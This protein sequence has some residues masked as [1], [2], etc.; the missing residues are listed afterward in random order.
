M[1]NLSSMRAISPIG[2]II[3]AQMICS[4]TPAHATS[5]A[6]NSAGATYYLG[7]AN[8]Q[9]VSRTAGLFAVGETLSF[10]IVINNYDGGL[11]YW[12]LSSSGSPSQNIV[13]Q[14]PGLSNIKYTITGKYNDT[15]LT[16]TVFA[17]NPGTVTVTASCS[18]GITDSHDCGGLGN[19]CI[20]WDQQGPFGPTAR[21]MSSRS[22]RQQTNGATDNAMAIWLMN[23]GQLVQSASLGSIP[24]AWSIIGQRD[25]NGDGLADVLWRDDSGDLAIWQAAMRRL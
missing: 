22:T 3:I 15:T 1:A 25:F 12:R 19:S 17:A 13:D 8:N 5:P 20:L 23:G 14:V 18:G 7:V 6:C 16:E 24:S 10:R 4:G 11:G 2:A 9:Q 21:Q